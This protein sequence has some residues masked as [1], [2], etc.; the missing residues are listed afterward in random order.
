MTETTREY[1]IITAGVKPKGEYQAYPTLEEARQHGSD[2]GSEIQVRQVTRRYEYRYG[3]A[4]EDGSLLDGE[5]A[6]PWGGTKAKVLVSESHTQW[7]DYRLDA[8]QSACG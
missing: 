8:G 7:I 3:S 2:W 6:T 1:R 5:T 4:R